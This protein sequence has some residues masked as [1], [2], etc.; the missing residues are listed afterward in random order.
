MSVEIK[1]MVGGNE[2]SPEIFGNAMEAQVYKHIRDSITEKL[3]V[4]SGVLS[5]AVRRKSL[6]KEAVWIIWRGQGSFDSALLR[7]AQSAPLRMTGLGE[8]LS[9]S[10]TRV[11]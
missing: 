8:H 9:T 3:F 2:F 11:V 4:K 6:R 5:T 10:A 7:F 1:L